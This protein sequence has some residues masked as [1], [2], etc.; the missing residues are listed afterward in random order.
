MCA[1]AVRGDE[2]GVVESRSDGQAD[3]GVE[4][5]KAE[6]HNPLG[7]SELMQQHD[8]HSGDL[9]YGIGFSEDAGA[10][11]SPI[12]DCIKDRGD[13]ENADVPAEDQNRDSCRHE[14]LI[15][16]DQKQRAEQEF[17]RY[18]VQVL[19]QHCPL[20][21]DTG[22]HAVEC[23]SEACA[24]EEAEA[25]GVTIFENRGNEEGGEA[26]AEY[27]QKIGRGTERITPGSWILDHHVTDADGGRV[28][29][30]MRVG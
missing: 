8:G 15:H 28:S 16:K 17:V 11:L 3:G 9:S 24:E 22:E 23:V 21:Q 6:N 5:Y 7:V 2:P 18:G 29:D 12:R 25:Q 14:A 26:D 20:F 27:G 19:A 1:A 13:E 10:E 4:G 30:R